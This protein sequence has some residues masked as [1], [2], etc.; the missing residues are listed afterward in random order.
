M[1]MTSMSPAPRLIIVSSQFHPVVGG[2]ERQALELAVALRQR[3]VPVVVLT[4]H[5]VRRPRTCGWKPVPIIG[6]AYPR[7]RVVGP[8][9]AYLRGVLALKRLARQPVVVQL[10]TLDQFTLAVGLAAVASRIPVIV[11]ISGAVEMSDGYLSAQRGLR[12]WLARWL[13]RHATRVLALNPEIE[14]RLVT[15]GV[16][17]SAIL[18][19][20][21]A[22]PAKFF[23]LTDHS[24]QTRPD[25]SRLGVLSVGRLDKF[26]GG[27][28]LLRAWALVA[29]DLP[30]ARLTIVG[31]GPARPSL[32]ALAKNLSIAG[33]VSFSGP[34]LDVIEQYR[35]ADL[36]VL[37]SLQEGMPNAL[38]E[39]MASGLAC[40]ASDLPGTRGVVSD[41]T[42]GVLVPPGDP[43]ALANALLRLLA[44]GG[45]REKLGRAARERVQ[46]WASSRLVDT[47]MDLHRK[48]CA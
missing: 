18:H 29:K 17:D 26:K 42:S 7:V 11:R 4:L 32:E 25:A 35:N 43:Q 47:H 37:P 6:I 3:Q 48:V 24:T 13:L 21:N 8:L 22:I 27:D 46:P 9:M 41:G 12:P 44:D 19:L 2:A 34:S 30:D 1:A 38:L 15:L 20:P 5:D 28:V 40:V 39:A 23:A 33:S 45:V 36:F 14:D 10:Q 16:D 31:D